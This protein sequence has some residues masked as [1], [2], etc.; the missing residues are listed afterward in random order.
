MSAGNFQVPSL[1]STGESSPLQKMQNKQLPHAHLN[2][3][4]DMQAFV[5][6][7]FELCTA[8]IAD[9]KAVQLLFELL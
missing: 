7:G 4:Y 9:A 6:H 8:G 5:G 2:Q 3:V 1:H